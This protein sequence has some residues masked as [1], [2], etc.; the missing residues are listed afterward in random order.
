MN[1]RDKKRVVSK[2]IMRYAIWN[3]KGGVGKTF[4]TFMMAGEY[5]QANPTKKV[6]VIDLCP[7]ANISEIILGGN[8]KGSTVLDAILAQKPSRH[9]IGGYIDERI[10]SP[11]KTTGNESHFLINPATMHYNNN[12]STNLYMVVGDPSLELQA[13]VINQ[14]SQLPQPVDAW[15]QIHSWVIDLI[16]GIKKDLGED[17]MFFLDCNPSFSSY[18]VLAISKPRACL[19][20]ISTPPIHIVCIILTNLYKGICA[21][22]TYDN[23]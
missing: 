14:L 12:L 3:N 15:K 11:F 9:T 16:E 6:V 21:Y 17:T 8:G 4:L 5:A 18:T 22:N 7:Q 13:Q 20:F 23:H 19:A 2:K 1:D 10:N